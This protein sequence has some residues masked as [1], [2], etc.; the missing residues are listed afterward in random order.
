MNKTIKGCLRNVAAISAAVVAAV[1]AFGCAAKTPIKETVYDGDLL[2]FTSSDKSFADFMNDFAERNLRFN[3]H[4]VSGDDMVLGSGTGFAKN[5]ETMSLVWH[6]SVGNVLGEDKL[7]RIE[8]FLTGIT[9]DDLGMIYN[10]HNTFA[11]PSSEA[12]DGIPQGWPFPTWKNSNGKVCAFEFNYRAARSA[13]AV[14]SGGT[15]G[16][17]GDGYA[18]F[19]F[20]GSESTDFDMTYKDIGSLVVGGIDSTMA[21]IVEIEIGYTDT[22]ATIG[23]ETAVEDISI[24]WQTSDGGDTW[25]EAPMSLYCTAP[26]T[27]RYSFWGRKYFQMYLHPD[28][29]GKTVTAL[30]VRINC[31]D[32]KTL[33]LADGKINYIRPGFD[34]RQSNATYQF[35]LAVGNYA[36]YTNDTTFLK[37]IMP[38]ARKAMTFL[39][40]C[41]Q[42][43]KG[44][45]DIS[46]FYGHDGIGASIDAD[47][48][49]T[50][51]VGSGIGNGYWDILTAPEINI[52]ANTYYYQALKTMASLER[53]LADAGIT[54]EEKSSVKNRD[55]YGERVEYSYTAESLEALAE[56]VKTNIEKDIKP[57]RQAD[58]TYK[59]A[60]GLWNPTTGRFVSGIR[61]DNGAIIDYGFVYWNEEAVAAGIGTETQRKSVLDWISGKRIVSGDTSTGAD[62]YFYEFAP[63]FSTLQ[64]T[65]DYG[66]YYTSPGFSTQVQDGGAVMCWSYY[67]LMSRKEVYGAD[68]AFAR[69]KEIQ[70]WYEKVR[71]A[72]GD[73]VNFYGDYYMYLEDGTGIYTLQQSGITNGAIGLDTEFLESI[74]LI[75]S[76]PNAFFGLNASE[77]NTLSITNDLPSKLDWLKIDNMLYGGV[78]YSARLN[79]NSIVIDKIKNDVPSGYKIAFNFDEPNKKYKV[80]IDGKEVTDYTV[81]NGKIRIVTE[82]KETKIE[83]KEA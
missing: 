45:L 55:P 44:L 25:F 19:T 17:S 10:T 83:I 66:F 51:N 26:E 12:G 70:K 15:F 82:F 72:G 31:K 39:T 77:Y 76:L 81:S 38:K 54:I 78:R 7:Y 6:N 58:G 40:H 16:E 79:K 63:R 33:N 27:L 65:V 3:E 22:G 34:T 56:T 14:T 80:Y 41:L 60:G 52:E 75:N 35:L 50:K 53:R 47:G 20:A 29:N 68:N 61:K 62:V 49:P 46:Y 43:E 67:D 23:S 74:M 4:S 13:W 37:N 11:V 8:Q 28:W 69:L 9:Q 5:W 18:R 24:I 2:H 30:G 21:P 64:N 48:Y 36:A 42:G 57:E 73:G 32:G 59:N 71:A 1:S